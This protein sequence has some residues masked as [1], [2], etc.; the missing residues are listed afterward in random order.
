MTTY[1]MTTT[2]TS[3]QTPTTP[4]ANWNPGEGN[5][6]RKGVV[7][8]SLTYFGEESADWEGWATEQLARIG[9][10]EQKV[11]GYFKRTK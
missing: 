1:T 11:L 5:F 9:V 8:D 4:R 3:L 10:H 6:V 2:T 7:G